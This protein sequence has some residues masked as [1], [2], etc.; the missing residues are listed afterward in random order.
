VNYSWSFG[1]GFNG[2]GKYV[3]HSYDHSGN[4]TINLTVKDNAGA[5][6]T[7]RTYAFIVEPED[8][9]SPVKNETTNQS[10]ISYVGDLGYL[11]DNDSDGTYDVFYCNATGNK[12][13]VEKQENGTYLIDSNG[14]GI[15]DYQ[16]DSSSGLTEYQK[17][18]EEKK[19]PG[20][21]LILIVCAVFLIVF[22]RTKRRH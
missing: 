22:W 5:S 17:E 3:N 19:T 20:F 12:T 11:I 1:D 2:S 14:D 9:Q 18:I 15:W 21:E 4:Y 6:I 13:H 16:F 10:T 8:Q 7:T